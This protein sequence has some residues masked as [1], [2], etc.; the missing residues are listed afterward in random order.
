MPS[1]TLSSLSQSVL[2]LWSGA[3]TPGKPFRCRVSVRD[4]FEFS[5]PADVFVFVRIPPFG[6][7]IS[8]FPLN[9]TSLVT[10]YD[11]TVLGWKTE[12]SSLPLPFKFSVAYPL[13]TVMSRSMSMSS[14]A[15]LPTGDQS[16]A[17]TQIVI[18]D[19]VDCFGGVSRSSLPVSVYLFLYPSV[20]MIKTVFIE[21]YTPSLT[22]G[23]G[24]E[25][26]S[27]IQIVLS[28]KNN[29]KI[30]GEKSSVNVFWV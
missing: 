15:F 28:A 12:D 5:G 2:I 30:S 24:F 7:S 16:S 3:L 6:G 21:I 9:G 14:S 26:L 4:N 13:E 29:V 19:V 1:L 8:V 17:Y 18:L 10:A 27:F 11:L 23:H 22:T 25:A 20:S